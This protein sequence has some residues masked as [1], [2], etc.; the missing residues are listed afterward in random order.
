[1]HDT[2][3]LRCAATPNKRQRISA[4]LL[5]MTAAA[6]LAIMTLG[7]GATAAL[8]YGSPLA[9]AG[10]SEAAA[11]S[12]WGD[13]ASYF[14]ISNG[15]FENGTTDWALTG[16][17]SVISDN[18]P[19]RV[20]G[21]RDSYS[22]RLTPGASAESRTICI[23]SGEDSIRLFVRNPGVRGAV[24]HVDAIVRNPSNGSVGTAAFDVNGEYAPYGWSPTI[25]LKVPA[26]FN[27]CGTEEMTLRFTLRGVAATW[28]IDDVFI[29]PFKSW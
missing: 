24:L 6:S 9:C 29:D 1:M 25:Q 5:R 16:G 26:M 20:A 12:R 18:E 10:R 2:A 22:L 11:F 7:L 28:A 15:G 8:A 23:S 4:A 13:S 17:A 14:R 19:F 3:G 21:A 27:S